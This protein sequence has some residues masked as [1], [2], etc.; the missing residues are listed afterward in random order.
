MFPAG[1]VS[2]SMTNN[3]TGR[4]LAISRS[5]E[6]RLLVR[7]LEQKVQVVGHEAPRQRPQAAKLELL[8]KDLVESL[9]RKAVP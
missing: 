7:H 5:R 8:E 6:R 1:E 3:L 9:F 4:A 2:A